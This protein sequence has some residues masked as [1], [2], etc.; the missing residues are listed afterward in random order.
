M[1]EDRLY[2]KPI[3]GRGAELLVEHHTRRSSQDYEQGF[4]P[5]FEEAH[6]DSRPRRS[7]WRP[8]ERRT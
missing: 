5:P 3:L 8:D 6:R 1:P 2:P 4:K 7:P